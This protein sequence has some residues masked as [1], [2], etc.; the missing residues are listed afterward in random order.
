MNN[1]TYFELLMLNEL[2]VREQNKYGKIL[3]SDLRK[4]LFKVFRPGLFK[5]LQMLLELEKKLNFWGL[6]AR[7]AEEEN[8]E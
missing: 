7:K 4:S 3:E 2:V 1:F 8:N 5:R 6:E